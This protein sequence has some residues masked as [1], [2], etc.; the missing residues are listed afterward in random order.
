MVATWL[1]PRLFL[2]QR[3]AF[4]QKR[5]S[6]IAGKVSS[7]TKLAEDRLKTCTTSCTGFSLITA[8]QFEP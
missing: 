8:E 5:S 4:H 2:L 1:L 3:L 6:N 7:L